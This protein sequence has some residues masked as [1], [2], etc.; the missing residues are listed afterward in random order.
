M[1]LGEKRTPTRALLPVRG[2]S[3]A[4]APSWRGKGH[5]GRREESV[6]Q[7]S[8][9]LPTEID[10][11]TPRPRVPAVEHS[12]HRCHSKQCRLRPELQNSLELLT[13]RAGN[14]RGKVMVAARWNTSWMWTLTLWSSALLADSV[15]MA[16]AQGFTCRAGTSPSCLSYG[17]TICSSRGQC[18]DQDAVCFDQFQCNYEG[19]TCKSN[20]T[21]CGRDYDNLVND[22]NALVDRYN[23]LLADYEEAIDDMNELR[24][25]AIGLEDDLAALERCVRY[26]ASASAA[27]DCLS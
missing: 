22:H 21:E 13:I 24:D 1:E 16:S 25:L 27:Q 7:G 4:P 2:P 10:E 17:E 20:L 18:V 26:A 6:S 9:R 15:S 23:G 11:E 3:L 8:F 12:R 14:W 5:R 19:F